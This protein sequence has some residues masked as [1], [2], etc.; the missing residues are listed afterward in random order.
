M[1]KLKDILAE[2]KNVELG[3]LITMKDDQPFMTEE[4]WN[5]KWET[6]SLL[7]EINEA[8]SSAE[9]K[10]I[11]QK[12]DKKIPLMQK[13]IA[14]VLS[15]NLKNDPKVRKILKK[16]LETGKVTRSDA[17]EVWPRIVTYTSKFFGTGIL[18][19]T[20][21]L[22]GGTAIAALP[23][24]I[25]LIFAFFHYDPAGI[26]KNFVPGGLTSEERKEWLKILN[27]RAEQASKQG[28]SPLKAIGLTDHWMM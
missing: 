23:L 26:M 16:F 18:A 9:V 13:W 10:K 25:A 27:K 6:N 20:F 2:S 8:K 22:L 24:T 21:V 5:A 1:I 28:K 4:Q 17:M 14:K 15:S 11:V 7:K 12:V 19:S 3:K